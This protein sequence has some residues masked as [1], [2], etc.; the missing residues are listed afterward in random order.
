MK[1]KFKPVF[2]LLGCWKSHNTSLL[3]PSLMVQNVTS[4]TFGWAR[5]SLLCKLFSGRRDQLPV[6]SRG[7]WGASPAG[8]RRLQGVPREPSQLAQNLRS[9]D[10]SSSAQAQELW[11]MGLAA[12]WHVGSS[13]TRDRTQISCTGSWI[14]YHWGTKEVPECEFNHIYIFFNQT[15]QSTSWETLGWRNHRLESRLPGEISITSDMQMTPSL[16]QK[17]KRN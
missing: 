10:S 14:L 8:E 16:W 2:H 17:V 15:M 12:P 9:T 13:H 5:S 3:W 7:S 1:I 11:P 6:S 4:F